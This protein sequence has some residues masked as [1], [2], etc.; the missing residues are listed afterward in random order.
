MTCKCGLIFVM[1]AKS[2][3]S[4][5]ISTLTFNADC[6]AKSECRKLT[7]SEVFGSYPS[8]GLTEAL[9]LVRLPPM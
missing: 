8:M 6:L 5:R 9:C 4:L 3:V 7:M 1:G 2:H